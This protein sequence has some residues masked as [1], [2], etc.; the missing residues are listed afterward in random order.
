MS[1]VRITRISFEHH[2]DGFGIGHAK[3]RLSWRF[4]SEG[5]DFKDWSQESYEVKIGASKDDV[6]Q[7]YSI[8]SSS[9]VLVP[10]PGP[11]LC[12]RQSAWVQIRAHG[13]ATYANDGQRHAA[14]TEWSDTTSVEVALLSATDWTAKMI[15]SQL[16]VAGNEPLRPLLFRRP[17]T[18]PKE[19]TSIHKARLYI[20]AHG[21]YRAH[22][23]GCRV[24][25]EEMA[26]G[27]TS[28]N[29]RLHYQV[30]DVTSTL[31]SAESNV[32]GLEV[33]E[34]WFAGRL[35]WENKR[36]HY[37]DRLGFVAQL[38]IYGEDGQVLKVVSDQDWKSCHSATTRSEIYDGEEYDFRLEQAGWTDDPAFDA[39]SW[40]GTVQ[41][42]FQCA[43]LVAP[44][45]P[46]VREIETV[47]P[48]KI[49]KSEGGNTLID[50]G[51][52][53]TGKLQVQLPSSTN[54]PLEGHTISFKHAEVLELGELCT[55]PLRSAKPVDSVTLSATQPTTWSPKFTF[56]GFRYAQVDG[57]P[58]Q[59]GLPTSNDIKA[60]VMHSDM[61][62]TGW[63]SCSDP[64]VNQLHE[65][66]IWS[67]KG[68]FLSVPTDCP[69]RDERL[70]WTGDIQLFTPSASFLYGI[71]GFM[72][73]WLADLSAEQLE[74]RRK[75]VPGV[76]IP[77][78]LSIPPNPPDPQC[79]WHDVTVLTPWD[80]YIS[81]GDRELLR[82]QY[83]SMKAWVDQGLPRGANGLWDQNVW[84][85]GDWLDPTAPPE[86][87][88]KAATDSLLVADAY[89]VRVL[90]TITKVSAILGESEDLLRYTA[91]AAR[92]RAAFQHEY[93]TPAGLLAS[94]TQTAH[95]LALVF[96]LFNTPNQ[97]ASSADRLAHLVHS[98]RYRIATG[99][100]GTPLITHALSDS[101]N[102]QLAYRMLLEKSC[103]SWLY[104]ITMG[105]TTIWER[106]DSMLPD[107]SINPGTMT[108][109]NHYALGSV[110]NWL[111]KNVAGLSPL[112]PGWQK[113]RVRPV[114]GG[115][116]TNAEATYDSPY[117]RI[118]CSWK[119]SEKDGTFHL[120]L[121][122]PPNS[123][124]V[125]I[126]PSEWKKAG[127]GEEKGIEVGS[128][129]HCFSCCF[130][131]DEWPP[132][133]KL[134]RSTFR[135]DTG[136]A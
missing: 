79:A 56:H 54:Q 70:G 75:G 86:E 19:M 6:G 127:P 113:I 129:K 65:N 17:F 24:G 51:Q 90:E 84:Q 122:I 73:N 38:E 21:L 58:T 67:M 45:S 25:N 126:L 102:H 55:R 20:S 101:G 120:T 130:K 107:G 16:P 50:F 31:R 105:A 11:P 106:W 117:G 100:V 1:T 93:V 132:R 36:Y 62:R 9:S 82:A 124:A 80:S 99:F 52:N 97:M 42:P 57:W 69:Q 88:G 44:D 91:D 10:W 94:D 22:I 12:S 121:S 46:P 77:D 114:P 39:A 125:V 66:A 72:G 89:L 27:W 95:A 118:E 23:N 85:Y 28:Y 61:T 133:A 74:D 37:G 48:V 134:R 33:A 78:V 40:C 87:P 29:H 98:A 41:V 116:I 4:S 35:A 103:P 112:E 13:T 131:Q 115:T 128:G 63:F 60:V 81:S 123:Q 34:G 64:L 7:I 47:A 68:N 136:S 32:F 59:L 111:H 96:G 2:P 26:P 53:L 119:V 49:W 92:V 104:P 76:V 43:T 15:S 14:S 5:A 3:P 30:Y 135:L 110:V 71:S 8:Q 83:A 108:S 18:L 109:F